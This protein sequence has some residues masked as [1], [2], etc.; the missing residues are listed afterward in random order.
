M[1]L[2][3]RRNIALKTDGE[4]A[5][6]GVQNKIIASREGQ[7]LPRNP[8]A[9]NPESNGPIEKGVQ[10]LNGQIRC[11]KIALEARIKERVKASSAIMEWGVQHAGFIATRFTVGHDGKTPWERLG[12]RKWNRP[13]VE[14][15]EQV[16]GKLARQRM[17]RKDRSK[18]RTAKRKLTTRWALGTWVGVVER[19]GESIIV[20][21]S[22]SRAVRVRFIKRVVERARWD[23][24][25]VLG[26]EA[27]P[28]FPD[29][30]RKEEYGQEI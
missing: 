15:G 8:P 22:S 16:L 21:K 28:R 2:L 26:I 14:F 6:L 17:D 25:T 13:L 23:P 27:T 20:T 10:D 24:K 7:T 30:K 3:G 11:I 4:P 29:P 5:I 12:G 9:Y 19:T 18:N 1:Q